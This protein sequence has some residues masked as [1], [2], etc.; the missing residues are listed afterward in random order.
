VR[1]DGDRGA[2]RIGVFGAHP[3]F[4]EQ[5]DIQRN[6]GAIDQFLGRDEVI[7]SF[8]VG[9]GADFPDFVAIEEGG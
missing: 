2:L 9:P 1:F 5:R 4:A 7:V 3:V 8:F 6:D